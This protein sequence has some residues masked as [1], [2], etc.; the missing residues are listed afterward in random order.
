MIHVVCDE[1]MG[2]YPQPVWVVVQQRAANCALPSYVQSKRINLPCFKVKRYQ[3]NGKTE[4]R[5]RATTVLMSSIVMDISV[6]SCRDL[7]FVV[8]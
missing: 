2:F 3:I 8:T 6:T 5:F 1:V 4:A 7:F